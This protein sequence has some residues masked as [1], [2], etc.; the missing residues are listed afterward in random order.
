MAAHETCHAAQQAELNKTA[1][2]ISARIAR[3]HAETAMQTAANEELAK[4]YGCS[5]PQI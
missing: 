3:H 4:K 5:Q 2:I 1:K